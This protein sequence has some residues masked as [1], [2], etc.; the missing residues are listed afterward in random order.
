MDYYCPRCKSVIPIKFSK[1][2]VQY[3]CFHCGVMIYPRFSEP[4]EESEAQ[5]AVSEVE[6]IF[7]DF[8][9]KDA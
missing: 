8:G 3:T 1:A 4:I 6:E 7:K 5:D 2:D 9:R